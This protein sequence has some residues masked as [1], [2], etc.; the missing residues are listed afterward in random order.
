M[1]RLCAFATPLI[2]RLTVFLHT[3][4]LTPESSTRKAAYIKMRAAMTRDD[5]LNARAFDW[6]CHISTLKGSISHRGGR[7]QPDTPRVGISGGRA[8]RPAGERALLP[9]TR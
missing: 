3:A 7:R 2:H 6:S 4:N 1:R 8:G 5:D 9:V